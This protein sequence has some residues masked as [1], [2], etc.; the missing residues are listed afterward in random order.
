MRLM[1]CTVSTARNGK[2]WPAASVRRQFAR[3]RTSP[4]RTGGSGQISGSFTVQQANDLSILL[5]AG[6]LPAPLTV[7]E[8]RVVGASLGQCRG[9]AEA[10]AGGGAGDDGCLAGNLHD[11]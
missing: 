7:I 4:S 5:R 10:D 6:A 9:D 2:R 1:C 3:R 11:P 8:E